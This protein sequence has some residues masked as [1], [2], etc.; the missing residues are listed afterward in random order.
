[1]STSHSKG[2]GFFVG[3]IYG[4]AVS[5]MLYLVLSFLYPINI[6]NASAP[7]EMAES[8]VSGSAENT[9]VEEASPG[10]NTSPAVSES[11]SVP[12]IPAAPPQSN[13]PAAPDTGMASMAQPEI[14]ESNS[15]AIGGAGDS[16]PASLV[17]PQIAGSEARAEPVVETASAEVPNIGNVA[18]GS[19]VP[20]QSASVATISASPAVTAAPATAPAELSPSASGP[21]VEVFAV[22]F[23]GDASKPML[24]II[25]ED[26]LETSLADLYATDTPL[27][28]ALP[29]DADSSVSAQS[30]RESGYEVVAMLPSGM[31]RTEGV[32]ETISGYM[33]NVPVAVA[34]IDAP[35]SGVM[36]NR[37]A[38]REVLDATR[39]AGLGLITFAGTGDLVARDQA[40]RAGA[41]YGNVVQV[42]DE[43]Q[44]IDLILQSLDRAAFDALTKGSAI[45]FARTRPATIEAVIRWL[46]GAFA[47]RLQIV[48]VSVA[49]QRPAN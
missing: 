2:G 1:M 37:D 45:V 27:S 23:T 33:Q 21:A 16:S 46:D 35:D 38:M 12:A 9:I 42:I 18:S 39:P 11:S 24:A 8:G 41:A 40:L 30:I 49:I 7:V 15:I 36:L 43:S 48:P 31:S 29:A 26:T 3:V 5:I 14:G 17:N 6:S 47:Q 25:L 32:S 13:L 44:D 19:E 4:V 22:A 28:F 34:L 20:G 10:L